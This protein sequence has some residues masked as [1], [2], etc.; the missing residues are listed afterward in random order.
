MWLRPEPGPPRPG[1]SGSGRGPGRHGARHQCW[2]RLHPVGAGGQGYR[3][4][5][6]QKSPQRHQG[7][8]H[9]PGQAPVDA[10]QTWPSAWS[11]N[12]SAW[13]PPRPREKGMVDLV[14][15]DLGDLIKKLEGR[16]APV[17]GGS[18]KTGPDRAQPA[19]SQPPGRAS[20]FLSLLANP[21]LAY[22]LMMIGMMGLFFELSHPGGIF[23]R[24][25]RGHQPDPGPLCHVH[26]A[27]SPTLAWP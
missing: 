5:N 6:G 24:G 8:Y 16:Q 10:T 15:R 1:L 25:G 17:A 23:P 4:R 14:A 11:P 18:K 20:A 22:I 27:R 9:Q 21:S 7:P 19:L 13:T 2:A 26:P 12:P 3:G